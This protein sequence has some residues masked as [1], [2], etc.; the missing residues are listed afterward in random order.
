MELFAPICSFEF[1]S[2]LLT[3]FHSSGPDFAGIYV[4]M[5]VH[6]PNIVTLGGFNVTVMLHGVKQFNLE[7]A[8]FIL[9]SGAVHRRPS[10][11]FGLRMVA[12]VQYCYQYIK[13]GLSDCLST[14]MDSIFIL[15]EMW[16]AL[17]SKELTLKGERW[18]KIN[19]SLVARMEWKCCSFRKSARL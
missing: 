13:F 10:Y 7:R 16:G 14:E 3:V 19:R 6:R 18:E 1:Y 9:M 11:G 8:C 5:T 2:M 15:I 17:D 4:S 12:L